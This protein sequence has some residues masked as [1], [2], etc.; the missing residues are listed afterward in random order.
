[1]AIG[2]KL[3]HGERARQ[4]RL[5]PSKAKVFGIKKQLDEAGIAY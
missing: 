3:V 4:Q 5:E 2:K 1:M